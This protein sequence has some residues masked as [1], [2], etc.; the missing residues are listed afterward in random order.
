MA[1]K[2][3]DLSLYENSILKLS[4]GA[5]PIFYIINAYTGKIGAP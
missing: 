5:L 2:N 1:W 4:K 3:K